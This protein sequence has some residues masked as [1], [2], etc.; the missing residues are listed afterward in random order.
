MAA[1]AAIERLITTLGAKRSGAGWLAR[2]PAHEDAEASLRISVGRKQP[3]VLRCMGGCETRV[4]LDVIGLTFADLRDGGAPT[5][6]RPRRTVYPI[7]DAAG[8]LVAEHIRLDYPDGTKK[9]FWRRDGQDTLG[10]LAVEDIPLYGSEALA[11][12]PPDSTIVVTEGEKA[13]DALARRGITAVATVTGAATCPSVEVLGVLVGQDAAL[14]PDNDR[15]GRAHMERLAER[16]HGLGVRPRWITWPAAPE[17]GDA[18]DFTATTDALRALVDAAAE[19]SDKAAKPI[20]ETDGEVREALGKPRVRFQMFNEE[21]VMS[22]PVPEPL[23]EMFPLVVTAP[24]AALSPVLAIAPA[25][26]TV[27]GNVV[28]PSLLP[29]IR[30]SLA[31]VPWL[32][33]S[34][35]VRTL[36]ELFVASVWLN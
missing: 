29:R 12:L 33:T 16:L 21:D 1:S 25:R 9:C 6:G 3:V 2:C 26:V 22:L 8:T 36:F 20:A 4:V 32:F 31:P 19:F 23:V 17:H 5:R 35:A 15:A 18:A 24:D 34:S 7:R 14:W 27:N 10:G 11:A 30:N 13:C 28:P